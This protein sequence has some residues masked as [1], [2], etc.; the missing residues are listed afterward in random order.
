MQCC[1]PVKGR[2]QVMLCFIGSFYFAF[3]EVGASQTQTD[4]VLQQSRIVQWKH[5]LKDLE[6]HG[7]SLSPAEQLLLKKNDEGAIR[8]LVIRYARF[9]DTGQINKDQFQ[10]EWMVQDKPSEYRVDDMNPREVFNRLAPQWP[11]YRLLQQHLLRLQQWSR[12][13]AQLIPEYLILPENGQHPALELLGKWLV[14][15]GLLNSLPVSHFSALHKK[16]LVRF[17]QYVGLPVSGQLT[18][19]TRRHLLLLTH[20]RISTLKI[21]MERL[22]WLPQSL[23]YP[24]VQVDIAGYQA[25]IVKNSR[26]EH[27][28]SV[29]VGSP[30]NPTPVFE[31]TI[32]SVTVNPS[33]TVP[34]M[35]AKN[36]L[37]EKE[38]E[39]P[40]YLAQQGFVV[41]G[42]WAPGAQRYDPE[43]IKWSTFDAQTFSF[44]L[45]QKPG[46]YNSLGHYKLNLSNPFHVYLHDTDKPALFRHGIRALSAGC[47]RVKDIS[48]FIH[49]LLQLQGIA[50]NLNNFA[51]SGQTLKLAFRQAV[52][53]F[54]L[55]FTAWPDEH[56]SIRFRDDI[57]GWDRQLLAVV[58]RHMTAKLP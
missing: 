50:V 27:R 21:N 56:G 25:L 22:R 35:L 31:D 15:L 57:Y 58:N 24:H 26:Q 4:V 29:I 45:V 3:D 23:P 9:M 8:Q 17:Q 1:L 20:K 54:F 41:Y 37:L 47:V 14:D 55:Y 6:Q 43:T 42:S 16:V 18:A 28:Y 44:K 5:E 19:E 13:S 7:I 51:L 48:V 10:P 49:R 32:K 46:P 30:G 34:P 38:K 12:Q 11:A 39:Q 36:R 52:P 53:V 33:W 2:W 40:G